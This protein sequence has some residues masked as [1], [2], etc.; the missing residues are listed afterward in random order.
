[1]EEADC[2]QERYEVSVSFFFVLSSLYF[3]FA[4]SGLLVLWMDRSAG[5][6][7]DLIFSII[8][9]SQIPLFHDSIILL[10][11]D[12]HFRQKELL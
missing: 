12:Q 1:M 4:F 3:Q 8:L 9:C 2:Q 5:T 11:V 6:N 7:H 10:L